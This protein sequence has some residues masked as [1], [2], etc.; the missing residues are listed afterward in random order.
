MRANVLHI[1]VPI[2]KLD[3]LDTARP[4]IRRTSLGAFKGVWKAVWKFFRQ[5]VGVTALRAEWGLASITVM[6]HAPSNS[7][8]LKAWT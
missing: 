2:S 8:G 7:M 6:T 5:T 3:N 4:R 1:K